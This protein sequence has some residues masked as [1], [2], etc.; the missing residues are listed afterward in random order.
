MHIL[1]NNTTVGGKYKNIYEYTVTQR[2]TGNDFFTDCIDRRYI[3]IR[4]NDGIR[5]ITITTLDVE[6]NRLVGNG[7]SIVRPC[8]G[9]YTLS[10]FVVVESYA[11]Y[12][13]NIDSGGPN[14]VYVRFD[15]FPNNS[16]KLSKVGTSLEYLDM[17][18]NAKVTLGG[19]I[20]S[21]SLVAMSDRL[22]LITGKYVIAYTAHDNRFAVETN[23]LLDK[24]EWIK[25]RDDILYLCNKTTI[26]KYD[27]INIEQILQLNYDDRLSGYIVMRHDIIILKFVVNAI[28]TDVFIID[29]KRPDTV[30]FFIGRFL[31]STISASCDGK[32]FAAM[33]RTVDNRDGT[34][35][36]LLHSIRMLAKIDMKGSL[37]LFELA[38]RAVKNNPQIYD[39]LSREQRERLGIPWDTTDRMREVT[40]INITDND[41]I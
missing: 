15:N 20:Q 27:G 13:M 23:T 6:Q 7:D 12:K 10:M 21:C 38:S 29:L 28:H 11:K 33:D 14:L 36:F 39:R 25:Y 24:Y 32:H 4:K 30:L 34:I 2:I 18:T 17:T 41:V 26:H 16:I 9:W 37:N 19:N 8:N 40:T 3:R 35:T 31:T 5:S 22:L 1:D